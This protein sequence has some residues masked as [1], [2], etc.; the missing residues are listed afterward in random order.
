MQLT[1]TTV[2]T[3]DGVAQGP[4]SPDEDRSG[5]FDHGGWVVPLLDF[6]VVL[7]SGRRLSD[8]VV[9]TGLELAGSRTSTNGI[10]LQ[11]YRAAGRP[12]FGTVPPMG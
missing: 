4:G 11:T 7:G 12:A 6:P 5:G 1:V 10:M 3:I 8:G 2:V 9:P